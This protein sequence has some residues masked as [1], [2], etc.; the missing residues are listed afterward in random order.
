MEFSV[1]VKLTFFEHNLKVISHNLKP[2]RRR[3]LMIS[4][5]IERMQE[6]LNKCVTRWR[7]FR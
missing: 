5:E 3:I 6:A 1:K 2:G 7:S 4:D